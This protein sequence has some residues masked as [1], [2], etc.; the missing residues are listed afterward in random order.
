MFRR[1]IRRT[2]RRPSKRR[3]SSTAYP[4]RSSPISDLCRPASPPCMVSQAFDHMVPAG[5][6]KGGREEIPHLRS[7]RELS[8]RDRH[9]RRLHPQHDLGGQSPTPANLSQ[10]GEWRYSM[11]GLA[12]RD[13]I[14]FAQLDTESTVHAA[15]GR[16]CRRR[17]FRSGLLSSMPRRDGP[18]S[19][20][21]RQRQRAEHFAHAR[22]VAGSQ[23]QIRRTRARRRLMRGLPSHDRR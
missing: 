20:S 21:H 17:S 4:I 14:F 1:G 11:M 9:T 6:S 2:C 5:E 22:R 7:M 19:I 8:R 13:P 16:P 18:A 15:S 12:G 23:I 10:Y 3:C